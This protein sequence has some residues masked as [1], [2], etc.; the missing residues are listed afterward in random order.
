V[1]ERAE[2]VHRCVDVLSSTPSGL[3][4]DIDGTISVMAPTP[5]EAVVTEAARDALRGLAER[6]A[7]V[8]VVTG[9]SASVGE[10]LVGVPGLIYVGNHGTE[11]R[12]NGVSRVHPEAAANAAV[13][14]EALNGVYERAC[15]L[16]V[17]DGLVVEDKGLSGSIH[18]RLSPQPEQARSVLVELA[19]EAA[20]EAGLLVTEGRLV[21]ELRPRLGVNKGTALVDLV[22][23]HHLRG[24]VFLGDDLTDVDAFRAVR[25]L[26]D[27]G[28]VDGLRLGVLAPE[29]QPEVLAETDVTVHGVHECVEVLQGIVERLSTLS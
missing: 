22:R 7:F 28:E 2:A 11:R 10:A 15:A 25:E 27:A 9:R 19:N 6:L 18:Y 29:T 16:G 20:A 14:G 24:I 1:G 8:G 21:V 5:G 3:I 17:G 13:L 23:E 4:T 12:Q 26:R